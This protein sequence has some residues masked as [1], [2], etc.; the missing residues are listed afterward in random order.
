MPKA[1]SALYNHNARAATARQLNISSNASGRT[2]LSFPS[3]QV[4]LEPTAPEVRSENDYFTID[5]SMDIDEDYIPNDPSVTD[6]P[7]VI[8]V[9]PGIRVL[10][11]QKAKR[12]ENSVRNLCFPNLLFIVCSNF[13][14][15]FH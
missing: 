8:E 4:P 14:R 15:M 11:K 9:M 7:R 6:E 2:T 10:A 12:Y 3:S 13:H 5:P 1:P